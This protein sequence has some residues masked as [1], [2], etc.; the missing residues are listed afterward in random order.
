MKT[1]AR[2]SAALIL[3]GSAAV[4]G[5]TTI[6][7]GVEPVSSQAV[8]LVTGSAVSAVDNLLPPATHTNEVRKLIDSLPGSPEATGAAVILAETLVAD[9]A[10]LPRFSPDQAMRVR[11]MLYRLIEVGQKS[12]PDCCAAMIALRNQLDAAGP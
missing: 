6:E 10:R 4:A 7:P 3:T 1:L 11:L 12:N 9:L 8:P 5:T 2:I